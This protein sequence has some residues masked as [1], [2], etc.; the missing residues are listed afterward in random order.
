MPEGP[1]IATLA[2]LLGD[3]A[4]ANMV[5]ALMDGRALTAT[6]LALSA[7]VTPQTASAHLARLVASHLLVA[8]KHG[9]CRYF[10]LASTEAAQILE[11]LMGLAHHIGA[12]RARPGPKDAALR[13]ARLCYDHFAGE[14]A[15]ALLAAFRRQNLLAGDDALVLTQAG[16]EVFTRFGIDMASIEQGRRAPC[17][18]CLDWSERRPHL[19][20]ALGA[21]LLSAFLAR[22]WL[23][24]GPGRL[25]T[26]TPSGAAGLRQV[27]NA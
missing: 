23:H 6:E 3:P 14:R 4:R 20:G 21:A 27:F 5:S 19:A 17:R 9:R 10:R 13:T 11:T 1:P 26:L 25:L 18:L 15:V 16:R 7:G 12:A 2:A 24:R 22:A 8:E